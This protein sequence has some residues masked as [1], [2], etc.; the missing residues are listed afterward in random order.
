M[1]CEKCK[2]NKATTHLHTV[3]NGIVKDAY[4]CSECA[5][6]YKASQFD[7]SELFDIM[8]SFFN[9]SLRVKNDVKC[10]KCGSTFQE[11]KTKGRLGCAN[12]YSTFVEQ[13]NET[14]LKLHGSTVHK[15]KR[16]FGDTKNNA[17]KNDEKY[18]LISDLKEKLK[19]AIEN[20]EYE[21]AAVL[22]DE[23]KRLEG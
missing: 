23:I 15:G 16:P 3:S 5:K 6:V 7:N 18:D 19:L 9:D 20:E 8:Q 4:L 22:R 10:D 17:E 21:K 1:I 14:I 13:L 12:C 2:K 11:V